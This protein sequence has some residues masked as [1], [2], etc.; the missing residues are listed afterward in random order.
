MRILKVI[1]IYFEDFYQNMVDFSKP[2]LKPMKLKKLL[3]RALKTTAENQEG[4]IAVMALSL[5]ALLALFGMI[6]QAVTTSTVENIKNTN[7]Y[8]TARDIADSV[9]EALQ[10]DLNQ[11][12]SGYSTYIDNSPSSGLGEITCAPEDFES[13][14]AESRPMKHSICEKIAPYIG[15]NEVKVE[16]EVKG[17]SADSEK[18]TSG[19]PG[20]SGVPC[21][22]T[23]LPGTGSAGER[24]HL[25]SP[26]T[27][28]SLGQNASAGVDSSGQLAISNEET[29]TIPQI[30]YS[31]N[32]N[33]LTFGSALTDRVAI[34]LYYDSSNTSDQD[35]VHPFNSN[36]ELNGGTQAQRFIL[37]VRTACK[38]CDKRS[39][40]CEADTTICTEEDRYTLD[41]GTESSGQNDIVVQWQITGDCSGENCGMIAYTKYDSGVINKVHSSAIVE[42]SIN[43]S[44][45]SI[46]HMVLKSTRE[47]LFVD[48]EFVTNTSDYSLS[49][50]PKLHNILSNMESPVLSLFLNSQLLDESGN[51]I[52][53]LEY[54]LLT[55]QP[56]SNSEIEIISTI[57][58]NG[59]KFYKKITRQ[60]QKELIDFAIQ[61]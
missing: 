6:V 40:A 15:T 24:C 60:E 21:F 14:L 13:H 61:N 18:F 9:V 30:D 33:K 44:R 7:N 32:W 53:H 19:C 46:P 12:G 23:P 25:Y 3:L 8:Y 37:R 42:S 16:L 45:D 36:S 54:Q 5:F 55:E 17:R 38:P 11:H 51:N 58:V 59:N 20:M 56:V 31:C 10:Y 39:T 41:E 34:P 35:L 4:F 28:P 50:P 43:G 52:P 1:I 47:G 2:L 29:T 48:S 26:F 57:T 49:E 22:V 27:D